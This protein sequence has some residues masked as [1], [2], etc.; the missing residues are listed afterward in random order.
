MLAGALIGG[1]SP[2]GPASPPSWR[3]HSV[4]WG[5]V[6]KEAAVGAVSGAISGLAG[7]EAGWA[8]RAAIDTAA[9]VGEQVAS[10]ALSHKPLASSVGM[11]AAVHYGG[12]FLQVV[13]M[14]FFERSTEVAPAL[15]ISLARL[16]HSPYYS[17]KTP[18]YSA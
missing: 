16:C 13:Q 8:T 14:R 6:G 2:P 17:R 12:Q 15:T 3:P 5:Q 11:A 10:N 1:R 7:P 18:Y 4:D 9:S